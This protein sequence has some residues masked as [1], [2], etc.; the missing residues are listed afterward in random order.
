MKPRQ[1]I[2][3]Y[4]IIGSGFG[5]SVAAMRLTEKGYSVLVLEKGRRYR[6]Q[7][8]PKSN[9]NLPKSLW[10]PPLRLFGMLQLTMLNHVLVLHW[11][12]VGGGSLGYANVLLEPDEELF[13]NPGWKRLADWKAL[14]RPHYDTAKRMLGVTTNPRLWPA[15]QTIREIGEEW[16]MADSFQPTPVAVYFGEAGQTA[17]DPY[18]G[19]E[20]PPRT[21][22]IHC[23]ACMVG[24]RH[25]AKNTLVK[26]YLYFAEKWGAEV[27]SQAMVIDIKPL[28]TDQEDEARYEVVYHKLGDLL[29]RRKRVRAR[30]VIVSAGTIG[31]LQ[32]LTRARE[33]TKSLE[34]LSPRLGQRMRTNSESLTGAI[35][36]DKTVDYSQG[37]AITSIMKLDEQ[38]YVEPVRYPA[39]SGLLRLITAPMIDSDKGIGSRFLLTLAAIVRQPRNWLHMV[40]TGKWPERSTIMLLMQTND[41]MLH[42]KSGR[43]L[44]TLFR[45]GLVSEQDA[46]QP[47]PGEIPV[48]KVFTRRFAER[49]KG[50]AG[51]AITESV[52]KVPLT[53]HPLGGVSFGESAVDGVIDLNCEVHNY[54]GLYVVD[55]SIMPGN[56]GRN[57]S[58]TITALAEY[59]MSQIPTKATA[60]A[61]TSQA[62]SSTKPAL[63][64][65]RGD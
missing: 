51:A 43:S 6:D 59:A 25:N 1:S 60:S 10:L 14:L 42:I 56:P 38:T 12:G 27:L 28:A 32:L 49:S 17:D 29:K 15:D 9:W 24:C 36:W 5:G 62:A 20:G 23:G 44:W 65:T 11:T 55:G 18:F 8:F 22:C 53:A 54:P 30:H 3:D 13:D 19:G 21:G 16:G 47:I 37:V 26:N 45:R 35:S 40:A 31:T 63:Q 7:D 39:G 46:K 2:Y 52:L 48:G 57:P 33:V 41:S 4:I 61:Y 58:L 34:R 64:M 50:F